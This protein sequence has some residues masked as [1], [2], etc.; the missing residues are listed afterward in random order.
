MGILKRIARDQ[1]PGNVRKADGSGG[2][3][4]NIVIVDLIADFI[5]ALIRARVPVS[6]T[7]GGFYTHKFLRVSQRSGFRLHTPS[8]VGDLQEI[9]DFHLIIYEI[10]FTVINGF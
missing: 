5:A 10:V 6:W 8:R 9:G 2:E 3:P 4:R 1:R 7:D